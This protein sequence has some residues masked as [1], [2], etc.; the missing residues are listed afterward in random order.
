MFPSSF[1]SLV[2]GKAR[3]DPESS[4]TQLSL[5]RILTMTFLLTGLLSA[6]E[7][8]TLQHKPWLSSSLVWCSKAKCPCRLATRWSFRHPVPPGAAK[9]QQESASLGKWYLI[10]GEQDFSPSSRNDS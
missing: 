1:S 9:N 5:L 6:M 10:R 7:F 8:K 4:R 3:I 2:S